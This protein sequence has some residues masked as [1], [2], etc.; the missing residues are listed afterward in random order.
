MKNL[1]VVNDDRGETETAEP[2]CPVNEGTLGPVFQGTQGVSYC[3]TT[4]FDRRRNNALVGD[5]PSFRN[6]LDLWKVQ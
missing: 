4:R 1:A 5:V 2:A 3:H 6:D